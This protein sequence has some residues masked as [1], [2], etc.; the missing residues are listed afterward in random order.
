[1]LSNRAFGM[2]EVPVQLLASPSSPEM[3]RFLP[4][5][6]LDNMEDH[7]LRSAMPIGADSVNLDRPLV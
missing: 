7:S 5:F 3:S 4:R 6:I 2:Q 1:M